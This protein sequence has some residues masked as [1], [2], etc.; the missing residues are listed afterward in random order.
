MSRID[1]LICHVLP[2]AFL[3]AFVE[4]GRLVEL[5][6]AR[7]DRPSLA[8][9]KWVLCD[10]FIDSTRAASSACSFWSRACSLRNWVSLWA[11]STASA[12]LAS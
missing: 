2:H 8:E 1:R 10:R 7:R 12:F 11:S 3:L 9:G 5:R 6:V 4:E